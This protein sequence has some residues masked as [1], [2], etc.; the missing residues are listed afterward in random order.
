MNE[1]KLRALAKDLSKEP[2]HSPRALLGGQVILARCVDKCRSS[3]L[4]IHGEYEYWPCSLCAQW[5][6][7]T[8]IGHEELQDFVATGATDDEI[9]EWVEGKSKVRD[10]LE[11]IAWNNKMRDMRISDLPLE[12]QEY[13]E[14][15]IKEYLPAGRPL[16]VWFDMWDIEEGRI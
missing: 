16:Y 1:E 9:A 11:I 8:G 6:P 5:S 2:P 15:Y 4:G 7:F 3:L 14:N 10:R 12:N 13:V